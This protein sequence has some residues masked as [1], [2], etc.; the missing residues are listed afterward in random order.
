MRQRVMAR[1]LVVALA[2][3]LAVACALLVALVRPGTASGEEQ[4]RAAEAR[5]AARGFTAYRMESRAGDCLQV[6]E[7]DGRHTLSLRRQPCFDRVRTVERLFAMV[8]RL[9]SWGLAAPRCAPAGCVCREIRRV[10]VTYDEQLGYPRL[11]RLL[12]RRTVDW[13]YLLRNPESAAR[14]T[15]CVDPEPI[16]LMEVLR[17]ERLR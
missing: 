4:L 9:D 2:G 14:L 12:P 3:G 16:V 11:I 17:L 8:E 15:E 1:R 10:S 6:G 7:F 13:L 5:W